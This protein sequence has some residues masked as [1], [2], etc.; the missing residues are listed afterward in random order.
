MLVRVQD[1][2]HEAFFGP[3]GLT[4]PYRREGQ[5]RNTLHFS[6]NSIVQDHP[7]GSFNLDSHGE[8]KGKIVLLA[9]P[10]EMSLPAGLS[11]VDTWYR[12]SADRDEK[13][14][15]VNRYL[16]LGHPT[17]VA[18]KGTAIPEGAN[19]IFYNGGIQ[20]RDAAVK[21]FFD[22]HQ[23]SLKPAGMRAWRGETED[24]AL[25]WAQRMA[26]SLYGK[27]ALH[28]HTGTH[29]AS[30]DANL[31]S[32]SVSGLVASLKGQWLAEQ[33]GI[34]TPYIALVENKHDSSISALQ[35]FLEEL[36]PSER[37]R[38]GPHY[39]NQ[40]AK[41]N[42]DLTEAR[43]LDVSWK[44]AMRTNNMNGICAELDTLPGK[45]DFFLAQKDKQGFEQLDSTTMAC[46][47]ADEK[48]NIHQSIWREGLTI[49]W[50]PI[51]AT[52]MARVVRHEWTP[53]STT[54]SVPPLMDFAHAANEDVHELNETGQLAP[55]G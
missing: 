30:L 27:E 49:D 20:E 12:L 54:S 14:G 1:S 45:G 4:L 37:Q 39:E 38:I 9:D 6:V 10:R 47:I 29:D 48:V 28:V 15:K 53:V 23:F 36:S 55:Q 25:Q 7:Y 40:I 8:L 2:L 52:P 22:A 3:G 50:T 42:A 11:Q 32:M 19:A 13:D 16:T 26:T 51:S 18:P 43:N 24:T 17:I 41:L 21:L 46:R 34:Q 35:Q 33:D 31:E 44:A 5:D